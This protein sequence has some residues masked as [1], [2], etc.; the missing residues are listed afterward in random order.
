MS[1]LLNARFVRRTGTWRPPIFAGAMNGGFDGLHRSAISADERQV[2]AV[3][4]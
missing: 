3:S 4:G 2:G 1:R